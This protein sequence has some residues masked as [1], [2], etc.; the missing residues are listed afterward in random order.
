MLRTVRA[1]ALT[2]ALSSFVLTGPAAAHATLERTEAP[3]DSY[4][5]AVIRVPHGCKGSPTLKVR[6]QIPDGVMGVKPQPK[7]GW[8]LAIDRPAARRAFRPVPPQRQAARPARRDALLEDRPGVRDGRSSVDR[9]PRGRQDRARLQGARAGVD[10]DAQ[11]AL[12]PAPRPPAGRMRCR[13]PPP[14]RDR[15]APG[16]ATARLLPA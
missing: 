4:Y 3:A 16:A 12:T 10:A 7:P 2:A 14:V 6:V 1:A 13:P 5:I 11:A 15:D 9:D 8:Q